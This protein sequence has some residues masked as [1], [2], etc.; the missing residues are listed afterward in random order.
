[1]Y[2]KRIAGVVGIETRGEHYDFREGDFRVFLNGEDKEG[3]RKNQILSSL[4]DELFSSALLNRVEGERKV[5]YFLKDSQSAPILVAAAEHGQSLTLSQLLAIKLVVE[6]E[7]VF[8]KGEQAYRIIRALWGLT[9]GARSE[10]SAPF[11]TLSK[12]DLKKVVVTR[13]RND[14]GKQRLRMTVPPGPMAGRLF[15]KQG[16]NIRHLGKVLGGGAD[17][18]PWV[19]VL[20]EKV[21]LKKVDPLEAL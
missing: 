2:V 19:E 18:H 3:A 16:A 13:D 10:K 7:S 1:M 6:Q 14:E 21:D 12:D 9:P 5:L 15:G 20:P 11:P 4:L 8:W 17:L